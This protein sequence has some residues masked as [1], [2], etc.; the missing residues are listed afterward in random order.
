[1][2]A[3][4]LIT[5]LLVLG[6]LTSTMGATC[7]DGD[8]NE[9]DKT[10][11]NKNDHDNI[12]TDGD[13]VLDINDCAPLD[14]SKWAE[15]DARPD[16]DGDNL[17]ENGPAMQ[18][19]SGNTTPAPIGWTWVASPLDPCPNDPQNICGTVNPTCQITAVA[20]GH[21]VS[22]T[23]TVAYTS[24]TIA[25]VEFYKGITLIGT[26][27]T[28]SN[29]WNLTWTNVPNGTYTL[30]A[31]AF[32]SDGK[33]ATSNEVTV[34][35]NVGAPTCVPTLAISWGYN[36]PQ[37]T[38]YYNSWYGSCFTTFDGQDP[39]WQYAPYGYCRECAQADEVFAGSFNEGFCDFNNTVPKVLNGNPLAP[40]TTDR[41]DIVD[42]ALVGYTDG[43][44]YNGLARM[45]TATFNNCI[46]T[47]SLPV[48]PVNQA[49]GANFRVYF[50]D[51][52]DPIDGDTINVIVSTPIDSDNDGFP[53][54][55]QPGTTCQADNCIRFENPE[56]TD[57]DHNGVGDACTNHANPDENDPDND[58]F[59]N[60][61]DAFPYDRTRH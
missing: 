31:I 16:T 46:T 20:S 24:G 12:D 25:R 23:A 18:V 54:A 56:Q 8:L 49:W 9:G 3:K 6:C 59:M 13:G 42:Y 55:C 4:R 36:I 61:E 50:T 30:Q 26:D 29:G 34:T 7:I 27:N 28:A 43:H 2:N 32:A 52:V 19:C 11:I 57:T 48:V 51:A 1:M 15:K 33:T 21:T 41:G 14:P 22:L 60:F 17:P 37:N 58:W 38:T 45:P 10:V 47:V 35:V 39:W 40:F 53:N 44:M 5:V